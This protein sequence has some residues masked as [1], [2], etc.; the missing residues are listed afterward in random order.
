MSYKSYKRTRKCRRYTMKR[1]RWSFKRTNRSLGRSATKACSLKAFR[2]ALLTMANR[3]KMVFPC[4]ET[5]I[6]MS[7]VPCHREKKGWTLED[8]IET[9][10]E[11]VSNQPH[12]EVRSTMRECHRTRNEWLNSVRVRARR[13]Q[14]KYPSEMALKRSFKRYWRMNASVN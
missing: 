1:W 10:S 6:L 5:W 12:R 9:K 8:R 2:R 3:W 4:K 7:H 14:N 11:A 13:S